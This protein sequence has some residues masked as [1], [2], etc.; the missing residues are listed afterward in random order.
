MCFHNWPRIPKSISRLAQE[1]LAKHSVVCVVV[2]YA[3]NLQTTAAWKLG[4]KVRCDNDVIQ[5]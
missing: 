1:L 5:T 2:E 3:A 4:A